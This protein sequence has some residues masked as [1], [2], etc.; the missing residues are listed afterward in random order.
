MAH[1]ALHSCLSA[2]LTCVC[3]LSGNVTET[4]TVE[5][6][7]MRSSTCAVRHHESLKTSI[8]VNVCEIIFHDL[9]CCFCVS[10]VDIQCET[11][12]RFR[13]DNNRCIYS[14]ELC[15]SMDDCGDGSDERQESCKF[16]NYSKLKLRATLALFLMELCFSVTR[17]KPNTWPLHK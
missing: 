9:F 1:T 10:A 14:H 15:N 4:T 16:E 11:P 17:S 12:F 8:M 7:L 13:C 6:T 5:T 2:R 3:S